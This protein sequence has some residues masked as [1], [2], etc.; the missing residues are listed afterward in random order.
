MFFLLM[1]AVTS[2]SDL[3]G[4]SLS[5]EHGG[6]STKGTP[7]IIGNLP[8]AEYEGSPRRYGPRQLDVSQS[9]PVLPSAQSLLASPSVYPPRP[10]FP[11]VNT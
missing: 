10:G 4:D 8:I 7:R 9:H 3:D 2:A 5:P 11:Q 1:Q 6:G